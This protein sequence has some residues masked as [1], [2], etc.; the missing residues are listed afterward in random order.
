MT[1]AEADLEC[2]QRN[3]E[4]TPDQPGVHW[5]VRESAPGEWRA[6]RVVIPG[7]RPRIPLKSSTESQPDQQPEV[8][9]LVD[10]NWGMPF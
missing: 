4:V 1:K 5:L 3:S 2:A 7:A 9:P 6:V 10:R 8:R